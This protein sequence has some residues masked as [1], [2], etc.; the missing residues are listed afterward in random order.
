VLQPLLFAA[1]PSSLL[2][3]TATNVTLTG[4][5]LP[6][7]SPPTFPLRCYLNGSTGAGLF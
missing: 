1:T 6:Q 4:A 5:E 2:K 7:P 3:V